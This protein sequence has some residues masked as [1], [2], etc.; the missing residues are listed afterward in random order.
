M[1]KKMEIEEE[2]GNEEENVLNNQY[3]KI[4]PFVIF[5]LALLLFFKIIEPMIT[6]F[7][8][9][10]LITYIFYPLYKRIRKRISIQSISIILTILVI[11]IILL[12]PFSYVVF[13]VTKQGFEFYDSLSSNIAKGALFG[14]GCTSAESNICSLINNIEKFSAQSLSTMGFDKQ[15]Q[16]LL[17]GLQEILTNYFIEVPLAILNG[18]FILFISFFL[19]KD[20]EKITQ[21]IVGWLPIRKQTIK[22]LMDQFEMVT[23]AVVFGSLFVALAQGFVGIIGFHIF[24]VPFPFFWG[25]MMAFF[26]M[27]PPVGTA[28]IWVPASL[29]MV[30]TGYFTNDY[31]TLSKGIGLFVYGLL[32][33]STIDEVLRIKIIQAKADVNPIIIIA[34]VIG[35]VNLF[36]VIGLF[37]GPIL[38]PLLITYF[39]TFRER[40]E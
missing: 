10:I 31:I 33:I 15:L 29:Y 30:L 1:A 20:G 2:M 4:V 17:P 14:I 27:I 25:F 28:V 13:E 23:Y 12:L 19:F 34:G 7:L 24:G 26:S 16:K 21:K 5:F 6:I 11:V 9:S 32:I 39:E 36:G 37:L 18:G 38:L 22:K 40:Y 8:S 3:E 35:G